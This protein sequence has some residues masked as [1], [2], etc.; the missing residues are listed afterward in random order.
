MLASLDAVDFAGENSGGLPLNK[1]RPI[2][3]SIVQQHKTVKGEAQVT[4]TNAAL[5]TL[6]YL[7]LLMSA[8]KQAVDVRLLSL[9]LCV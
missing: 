7:R 1:L 4:I 5:E 6:P 3:Q 2:I 9:V 8:S